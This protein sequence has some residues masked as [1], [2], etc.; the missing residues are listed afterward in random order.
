MIPPSK[1]TLNQ[2]IQIMSNINCFESDIME[3]HFEGNG[4]GEVQFIVQSK[5]I[6]TRDFK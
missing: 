1:L 5:I 6:R 4:S 3:S 2:A